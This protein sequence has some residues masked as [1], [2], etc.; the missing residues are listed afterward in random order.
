M[1]LF[2]LFR[3]GY[4]DIEDLKKINTVLNQHFTE[5]D[6]QGKNFKLKI[7]LKIKLK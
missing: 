4:V 5:D 1:Y 3:K 6:L 2:Y 7:K